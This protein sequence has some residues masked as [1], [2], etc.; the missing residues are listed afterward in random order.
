MLEYLEGLYNVSINE[1]YYGKNKKLLDIEKQIGRARSKYIGDKRTA[2]N[3]YNDKEIEKVGVMLSNYFGFDYVDFNLSNSVTANAYTMPIGRGILSGFTV[4]YQNFKNVLKRDKEGL[5]VKNGTDLAGLSLYVRVTTGLWNNPDITN[6]EVLAI[7]LHEIGH[8]FQSMNESSLHA[9]DMVLSTF[10]FITAITSGNLTPIGYDGNVRANINKSAKYDS[11]LVSFVNM[12]SLIR[13]C[14]S[15]IM[16]NFSDLL[17]LI[18]PFSSTIGSAI[19]NLLQKVKNNPLSILATPFNKG[20]EYYSDNFTNEL[21]YGAELATA[22]TKITV[23]RDA[24]AISKFVQGSNCIRELQDILTLIAE[25]I[26]SP[27]STHPKT[28]RRIGVMIKKL[29]SEL[30]KSDMSPAL[31]KEI[32]EQIKQLEEISEVMQK[33]DISNAQRSS[34]M[35]NMN[36]DMEPSV[37]AVIGNLLTESYEEDFTDDLFLEGYDFEYID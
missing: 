19:V 18:A 5:H 32:K 10:L 28:G 37:R 20:D 15:V 31:K 2:S 14:G 7:I 8:N 17:K 6:A 24:T 22:L 33:M 21:G 13:G 11:S 12:A 35:K 29:N 3:F 4:N 30:N 27:I 36:K 34:I 9:Y 1:A 26:V 23:D 16:H 25:S